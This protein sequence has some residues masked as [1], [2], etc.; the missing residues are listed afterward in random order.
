MNVGLR[1]STTAFLGTVNDDVILHDKSLPA[2]YKYIQ[3][4]FGSLNPVIY[5]LDQQVESAG[6]SVSKKGKA[7]PIISLPSK[8]IET[9]DASNAACVLYSHIGLKKVGL[10]DEKFESYLEDIDLSLRLA[11]SGF[12]NYVVKDSRIIHAKHQTSKKLGRY[13]RFLDVKNWWLVIIKNWSISDTLLHFPFILLERVRN[14]SG[15]LK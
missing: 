11:R 3:Y 7:H 4:P 12:S 2:L 13:K 5:S 15:F 10:F 8:S 6:I 9:A 14:I 1:A